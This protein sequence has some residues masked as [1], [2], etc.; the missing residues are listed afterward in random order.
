MCMYIYFHGKIKLA[1]L[2]MENSMLSGLR[3]PQSVNALNRGLLVLFLLILQAWAK[4]HSLGIS[5]PNSTCRIPF[6][7]PSSTSHLFCAPV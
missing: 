3:I 2:L 7:N 1:A 4:H 5:F 6:I